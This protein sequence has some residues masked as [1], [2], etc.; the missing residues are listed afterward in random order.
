MSILSKVKSVAKKVV[1]G[2]GAKL[3]KASVGFYNTVNT[4][5]KTI[6][7][8]I[9]QGKGGQ[10]V[11]AAYNAIPKKTSGTGGLDYSPNVATNLDGSN[12]YGRSDAGN[13]MSNKTVVGMTKYTPGYMTPAP[14]TVSSGKLSS[15]SNYSSLSYGTDLAALSASNFMTGGPIST[16]VS[17]SSLSSQSSPTG[18][19]GTIPS[20]PSRTNYQGTAV[21]G[22]VGV[23]ANP[24]NG[25][26]P[27][28]SATST[29]TEAEG[30]APKEDATSMYQ[31]AMDKLFKQK[32]SQDELY[33]K[34]MD[35]SGIQQ[36]RQQMQNTQN[37]INAITSKMNSD[38]L[39]L[40]G[41]A[42]QEGVTEAVYGGQQA[43]IT[44]EATI[45]L[46]PLQA[47]LAADQ[48]NLEMAESNLD[49]LFKIYSKDAEDSYNLY[50][51]QAKM[52]YDKATK[53][54]QRQYDANLMRM[55]E[56]SA[57]T[58]DWAKWQRDIMGK[59]MTEN[60]RLF[61]ALK[62]IIPPTNS[63]SP[64]YKQDQQNYIADLMEAGGQYGVVSQVGSGVTS[65]VVSN[66]QALEG[67]PAVQKN[68]EV[69]QAIFKN[70]K[71]SAG[72][73]TSI[74]NGLAL[75]QAA[76]DLAESA[77]GGEFSGL[78]PGR[79]VVDFF[80]PEALK[81]EQTVKNESLIS[82]LNLQ[83]QF[84]ASGAALS[85]EQTKLVE[86]MI[87]KKSDTDSAIRS[88]TNQ[89]VNYMLSQTSSRLVTEGINFKPEKVDLFNDTAGNAGG[90]ADPL[91]IL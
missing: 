82:A 12:T 79:G 91:G 52:Y 1:T 51:N 76:K 7:D 70:E 74:G 23:G 13:N 8:T 63:T 62:Q 26:I 61:N 66:N 47:Q 87:P 4:V 30:Q 21:G 55:K 54:E 46:L 19:A 2:V 36:A 9:T 86:K 28:S 39:Q 42:A 84:W 31:K 53:D 6:K 50:A 38:L 71:V 81:R 43:Q 16:S 58:D 32:D 72:A 37:S 65:G 33:S 41:T 24:E 10:L 56:E 49:T 40:R 5:G 45:Q 75:S 85:D 73:R 27:T 11:S 69:L 90:N 25:L 18:V 44:R 35:E 64:T 20:A 60:P 78:Y 59:A 83:T 80:T 34:A 89:L 48:G 14:K 22:N 15:K 57:A 3:K 68:Q 67:L 17:A 77:S 88:K 29:G